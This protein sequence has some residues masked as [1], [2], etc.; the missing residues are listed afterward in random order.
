MMDWTPLL[1]RELAA[2][3]REV[4]Q[5]VARTLVQDGEAAVE[6]AALFW[7][8]VTGAF[9]GPGYAASYDLA[10]QQLPAG[11][12]R[13]VWWLH[14]GTAGVA[15]TISH[16]IEGGG[17]DVLHE[18]DRRL[19][20][21]VSAYERIPCELN[22]GLA[23]IGAYFLERLAASADTNTV[24]EGLAAVT[25]R[26]EARATR[27]SDGVAWHTP[28][29]LIPLED[30]ARWPNGLT[31]LGAAHGVAGIL[32]VLGRI[33]RAHDPHG[34]AS[35]LCRDGL[36]WMRA[37]YREVTRRT[38]FPRYI[39]NGQRFGHPDDGWCTGDLGVAVICWRAAE[40]IAEPT[41]IWREVVHEAAARAP[42]ESRDEPGL[43]H[44]AFGLAHM[45]N[46][47]FQASGEPAFRDAARTWF[48]RGLA[49]RQPDGGF[50]IPH[51]E[52]ARTVGGADLLLGPIGIGLALLAAVSDEE[53][54][55]DRKLACD[56]GG[57]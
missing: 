42:V 53:P 16:I 32:S 17:D 56:L 13:D 31:S 18:I 12:S 47:C 43:C 22:T 1:D 34:R 37:C 20:A 15:W 41:G 46:R 11:L 23:G 51:L 55:W 7:A 27:T 48:A 4:V 14:G 26:L 39:A 50:A 40:C 52:A 21:M 29:E 2:T 36:R 3:A 35:S 9:E 38:R 28:P 49:M 25:E 33:A 45:L 5:K 54:G 24:H 44:G 10:T 57:S 30:R 6:D 8:Y 19:L